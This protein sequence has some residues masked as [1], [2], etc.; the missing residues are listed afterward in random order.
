M[1]DLGKLVDDYIDFC[2]PSIAGL[3]E[4]LSSEIRVV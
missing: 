1:I 4:E 2:S 3:F